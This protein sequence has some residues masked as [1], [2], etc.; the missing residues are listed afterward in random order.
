MVGKIGKVSIAIAV[1]AWSLWCIPAMVLC[2]SATFTVSAQPSPLCPAIEYSAQFLLPIFALFS[3][4]FILDIF[5]NDDTQ[6]KEMRRQIELEKQ[7]TQKPDDD[8]QRE[9]IMK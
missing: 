2:F 3:G 5:C 9:W 1:V 4:V 8:E 6:E 7:K